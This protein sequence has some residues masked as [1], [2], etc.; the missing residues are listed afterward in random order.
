MTLGGKEVQSDKQNSTAAAVHLGLLN[1]LAVSLAH[2][3][4]S[5]TQW[6]DATCK[7]QDLTCATEKGAAPVPVVCD[8]LC[9][10]LQTVCADLALHMRLPLPMWWEVYF[11][12]DA[13]QTVTA[14]WAN[15]QRGVLGMSP[16][17]GSPQWQRAGLG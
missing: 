4:W 10:L 8:F 14:Q 5:K 15:G 9:H 2:V 11:D 3:G 17:K 1:L 13:S 7:A 16:K 12:T 6:P